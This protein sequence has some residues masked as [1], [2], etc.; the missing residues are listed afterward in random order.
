MGVLPL[1]Q[2]KHGPQVAHPLVCESGGG[3]QFQ[4]LH[5]QGG[6]ADQEGAGVKLE[7]PFSIFFFR[8]IYGSTTSHH[9]PFNQGKGLGNSKL[10]GTFKETEVEGEKRRWLEWGWPENEGFNPAYD[11]QGL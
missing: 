10:V 3:D 6:G 11:L 1:I 9:P 2:Q 4:A 7:A 5:L 8:L